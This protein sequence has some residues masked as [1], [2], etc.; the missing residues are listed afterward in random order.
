LFNDQGIA[1]SC[2]SDVPGAIIMAVGQILTRQPT[3][4]VDIIKADL[5]ENSSIMYH[6][7]NLPTRLAASRAPLKLRPIPEHVGPG[8][9]GPT[10]QATL[11][12]GPV[13]AANLVGRHGS[14]RVCALEGEAVPYELEFPGSAAKILFPFPLAEALEKL[15]EAGYGHHFALIQGHV[16]RELGEWC[17]LS[18]VQFMQI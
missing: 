12:P 2:E 9:F 16:G 5:A 10:I 1:A 7:G 18:K 4:H 13:T 6:C 14:M 17:H 15:G 8:A 11:R 3:F